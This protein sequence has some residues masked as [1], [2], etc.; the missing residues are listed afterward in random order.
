[1][2]S[3]N[4][5]FK[6]I[7]DLATGTLTRTVNGVADVSWTVRGDCSVQMHKHIPMRSARR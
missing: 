2:T 5:R 3:E 4:T 7:H 1:M 6:W